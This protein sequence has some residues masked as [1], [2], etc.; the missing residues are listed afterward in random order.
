MHNSAEDGHSS[1]PWHQAAQPLTRLHDAD[2]LAGAAL[3]Q[4]AFPPSPP[5]CNWRSYQR[6]EIHASRTLPRQGV[7]Q[8]LADQ[9]ERRASHACAPVLGGLRGRSQ[10]RQSS[11]RA[12]VRAGAHA[13]SQ[14]RKARGSS[15]QRRRDQQWAARLVYDRRVK[16]QQSRKAMRSA[17]QRQ[18]RRMPGATHPQVCFGAPQPTPR[19]QLPSSQEFQTSLRLMPCF[20]LSPPR[21][22]CQMCGFSTLLELQAVNR[23]MP[24]PIGQHCCG[25]RASRQ[26]APTKTQLPAA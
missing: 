22:L 4:L 5:T 17:V 7:S 12:R 21:V 6:A 14:S 3:A 13:L 26:S 11:S 18:R 23:W 15:E 2:G 16:R 19:R 20:I 1:W 24:S 10:P 9:A 8:T 25:A